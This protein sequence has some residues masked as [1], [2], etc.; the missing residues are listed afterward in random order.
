LFR[1]RIDELMEEAE[2]PYADVYQ[3]EDGEWVYS[4]D[5]EEDY[6]TYDSE[7]EAQ[8]AADAELERIEKEKRTDIGNELDWDE[9]VRD[10]AEELAPPEPRYERYQMAGGENYRELLLTLPVGLSAAEEKE[11]LELN[12]RYIRGQVSEEDKA[13][14]GELNAKSQEAAKTYK[15]GHWSERNVLAHVRFNEREDAEGRRV[16]FIEEVQ[17]DWHQEGRKKG[18]RF[19]P[20]PVG[21]VRYDPSGDAQYP[22][23]IIVD[24]R[25]VN[26]SKS[27]ELS[28]DLLEEELQRAKSQGQ[29]KGVPD[30]PFKQSWPLLAMKRLIRLAAAEGYDRI[31]WT[32]GAVQAERYDLSRQ[33]KRVALS[34][35]GRL[36]VET[37]NGDV[38]KVA[39]GV[40]KDNLADYIGKDPAEH[41]MQ[42]GVANL[43]NAGFGY[44]SG[45]DMQGRVISGVDLRVG[46]EGMK[47]FYD[48]IL[49]AEVGK[50]VKKWGAKVGAMELGSRSVKPEWERVDEPPEGF[51]DG[52]E[53]GF[54]NENGYTDSVGVYYSA[55]SNGWW[56][57][58]QGNVLAEDVSRDMAEQAAM[59]EVR[60]LAVG[61][62]SSIMAHGIDITPSM[63]LSVLE[64]GQPLFSRGQGQLLAPNGRPS[65]LNEVQWQQVRTP[66]FK[67]FFGDWEIRAYAQEALAALRSVMAG[68]EG[69]RATFRH[70]LLGEITLDY[71]AAGNPDKGYRGGSGAAHILA[72]RMAEG[73]SLRDAAH[74]V[75]RAI[76]AAADGAIAREYGV[77]KSRVDV[78]LDGYTAVLSRQRFG[79][80]ETWVVTGFKNDAD[81]REQATRLARGYAPVDFGSRQQVGAAFDSTVDELM[82]EIKARASHV[83]DE[84]GE[85]LVVY[86]GTSADFNE[87]D[88]GKS[89][90]GFFFSDSKGMAG[91]FGGSTGGN[92]MPVFLNIRS[93]ASYREYE[94]ALRRA[95][96]ERNEVPNQLAGSGFDAIHIPTAVGDTTW[97]AFHPEQIKSA[98]GNSGE[99]SPA[100]PDIRY[101]LAE[102][103][104]ADLGEREDARQLWREFGTDSPYFRKWFGQSKIRK[105]GKPMVVYHG[106]NTEIAYF[107][108]ARLGA[109]TRHGT[110][111]LGFFF[112]VDRGAATDYAH[113]SAERGGRAHVG[114]YYLKI[115]NPYV[116]T[117]EL[118][119]RRM[120]AQPAEAFRKRLERD[121]YDGIY[122]KDAG[123]IVAF[124]PNQIKSTENLGTFDPADRDVRYSLAGNPADELAEIGNAVR[125]AARKRKDK[126]GARRFLEKL[127]RDARRQ[128]L[129]LLKRDQLVEVAA[130]LLPDMP[131]YLREARALDA[132]RNRV[133]EQ[134]GKLT[135]D[136]STL[137]SQDKAGAE[138]TAALMHDTTWHGVDPSK[139]YEQVLD[140]EE[141]K[142]EVGRIQS[143]MRA[144]VKIL[145]DRARMAPGEA[146]RFINEARI[147]RAEAMQQV[148]ELQN[149]LRQEK[150]RSKQY[151]PLRERWEALPQAWQRIFARVRDYHA[152]M[153]R[154]IETALIKRI[155]DS[156]ASPKAKR[157]LIAELREE[158]ESNR[159][160]APYFPL[161]RVGDY[162]VFTRDREGQTAFDM[163]ETREDQAD[164]MADVKEEGVEVLAHGK[165]AERVGDLPAVPAAF[166]ATVEE[167]LRALGE[168]DPA[169]KQLRDDI[170]QIY[171][172]SLPQ[173]SSRQHLRHR[174]K[175]AGYSEDALQSTARK[176]FHDGYM[177]ARLKHMHR[178]EQVLEDLSAEVDLAES[179]YRA[180]QVRRDLAMLK[181][182]RERRGTLDESAVDQA[183]RKANAEVEALQKRL[184]RAGIKE[185]RADL[186]QALKKAERERDQWLQFKRWRKDGYDPSEAIEQ[187]ERRLARAETV[188][189]AE[190]GSDRARDYIGELQQFHQEL[191]Q[192]SSGWLASALNSFGFVW[193]LG[194]S[195]ATAVVNSLQ[196]P[197]IGLPFAGAKYGWGPA[198]KAFQQ[199]FREYFS[200]RSLT[201]EKA[202][203]NKAKAAKPGSAERAEAV[204]EARAMRKLRMA[205]AFDKTL[206]HDLAGLAEQGVDYSGTRARFMVA[207]AKAFHETER[208]NREITARA[209]YLLAREALAG[210]GLSGQALEDQAIEDA[211]K[212]N[213]DVHQDY[214][215]A[216]RARFMRGDFRRVIFQFKQYSQGVTY[217]LLRSFHQAFKGATAEEKREARARLGGILAMQFLFAGAKGLPIGLAV[218][219]VEALGAL[220]GDDD[221][222]W[223]WEAEVRQG[224]V[225]L[226]ESAGLSPAAAR[227]F[228]HFVWKGGVD[229]L[230]PISVADRIGMSELWVR[231]PDKELEGE[232]LSL[233][234]YKSLLGPMAGIVENAALAGKL[235]GDGHLERGIEKLL[236]NWLANLL[237]AGRFGAEDART[238]QG[239][240]LVEDLSGT[241]IAGQVLGF[242]PSRLSERY[243]ENSAR[244]NLD[245]ALTDRRR[246]LL[247]AWAGAI[248]RKDGPALVEARREA[249]EFGKK[250]PAYAIRPDEV[251]QSVVMSA[252]MAAQAVDGAA[253]SR[254]ARRE[255]VGERY[256]FGV[257]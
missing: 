153:A 37:H 22:W 254:R 257:E 171:L 36:F 35:G 195:V 158:F 172:S 123:Y 229:A 90:E 25:E 140:V 54:E 94:A 57:Y 179:P 160:T 124:E 186:R 248:R 221:D 114:A 217:I 167:R 189:A 11:L 209:A 96:Y 237:K 175:R 222:P 62:K 190:H 18:Y 52:Y 66:E 127:G 121:G 144:R 93:P 108:K 200:D 253:L 71:G 240:P 157:D 48:R 86:H 192:P 70:P 113:K 243:A 46:G 61:E 42:S 210:K 14:I 236:P 147:A 43:S 53:W 27:E 80:D 193:Y 241:E 162:W 245:R 131:A 74:T 38:Q 247:T 235:I 126:S 136:W 21:E 20:N 128:M 10:A 187:K 215:A 134:V 154:E 109:A 118:L 223:D 231:D 78:E 220:F 180:E 161:G 181:E 9:F 29:R 163:F 227:R 77:G 87:F 168:H 206:A 159:V 173:L 219:A 135:H 60:P 218:W 246:E 176:G 191:I 1:A 47:G 59:Q 242:L 208:M 13:R 185:Q 199:A 98:I 75:A 184:D 55:E 202:L 32:P 8:A 203:L 82:A 106:T 45:R 110:A 252:R 117:A 232:D 101:S 251:R 216:N 137:A 85:P 73:A 214:T 79:K 201:I 7:E 169:V 41:L 99:F 250:H 23:A 103:A 152:D 39:D 112:A 239:L 56:A 58:Y 31:A 84:N 64:E 50:Y 34:E 24:G 89:T 249:L 28:S 150:R 129:G 15:S 207:M 230:S 164:F 115:E 5:G 244:T 95:D 224:L 212:L 125:A 139:P 111:G 83:V 30:A 165:K 198:R 225:D 65:K 141:A 174:K 188:A 183:I 3:N 100:N 81:A 170:W 234:L 146:G 138:A 142:A 204:R 233:Y 177:L 63:R 228:G 133:H 130:P 196:T 119:D 44:E 16:L 155:L 92:V 178:L 91:G 256:R 72:R 33:V 238:L 2:L 26:R 67:A 102:S 17:S 107:D 116:V 145:E 194:A 122:V 132:D 205:G 69:A 97:I 211:H 149:K 6:A 49:P 182:Y 197:I 19:G 4:L 166:V 120:G 151:E 105:G 76:L 148:R 51:D 226:G 12:E 40:T 143:A 255:G 156:Q 104:G 68:G 88:I 213:N